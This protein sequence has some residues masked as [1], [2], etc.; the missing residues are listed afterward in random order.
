MADTINGVIVEMLKG[1]KDVG[2]ELYQATHDSIVAGVDFAQEQAPL[3]VKE[4]LTWRGFEAGL[5]AG[6]A[7]L[8]VIGFIIAFVFAYKWLK[9]CNELKESPL[10]MLYAIGAAVV[11]I[12][13]LVF[14]PGQ[15][16]TITTSTFTL[17]KIKVAPRVYL[18]EYVT[19]QVKTVKASMDK[20][21]PAEPKKQ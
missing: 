16:S 15:L 4:F 5:Q 9:K 12:L 18:I 11:F 19:E 7:L 13:G 8:V 3:V 6:F 14:L 2:A 20:A 17:V 1:A 10:S 21:P